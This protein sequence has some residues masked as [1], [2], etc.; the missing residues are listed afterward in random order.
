MQLQSYAKAVLFL[1]ITILKIYKQKIK[2]NLKLR[3]SE[4]ISTS[5]Q[6]FKE[7]VTGVQHT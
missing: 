7:C 5:G 4:A 6:M 2:Q 1:K 3:I